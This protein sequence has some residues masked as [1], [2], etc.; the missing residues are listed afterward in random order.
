MMGVKTKPTIF[1]YYFL[2]CIVIIALLYMAFN[3]L[4]YPWLWYDEAGQF[5]I[6]KGLNHYSEPFSAP[7]SIRQVIVNNR[8]YNLDPGGFSILLHYWLLISDNYIFIRTLPFLFFL[9]FAFFLYKL[10]LNIIGS[11]LYAFICY[12]LVFVFGFTASRMIEVRAYS[13][14]MFGIM[15]VLFL[16]D[17][18]EKKKYKSLSLPFLISLIIA[19]FNT[20][21][22]EY[23]IFAFCVSLYV[24]FHIGK[25][26][27][28][29]IF[30]SLCYG[31]LPL[32]SVLLIVLITL[33]YQN[34]S[35][36]K[37]GYSHY[38]SEDYYLLYRRLF[39]VYI[40]NSSFVIYSYYK[41]KAISSL[42]YTS[43]MVSTTIV[44]LSFMGKYPWDYIR[45]VSV[46]L[47]LM[48]NLSIELY[49]RFSYKPFSA[50]IVMLVCFFSTPPNLYGARHSEYLNFI[51][52]INLLEK[53]NGKYRKIFVD[54]WY[55]PSIRYIYEYGI[56][57]EKRNKDDYP[58]TFVF[59][60]KIPKQLATDGILYS[61]PPL[62]GCNLFLIGRPRN[63]S[64]VEK[65]AIPHS[66]YNFL[67]F[68][69]NTDK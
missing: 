62:N 41:N 51:E 13:M 5:W 23:I 32:C 30:W 10:V 43:L 45:A 24:V 44:I 22:Y 2:G 14:E 19:I 67:F 16:I 52:A 15:L 56:Y 61:A 58:S 34:P 69:N 57:S 59:Q 55:N 50:V 49:N 37:T 9:G 11:R 6:S 53:D 4:T 64:I 27:S 8:Y 12:V 25:H 1:L 29:P 31:I 3:K 26:F 42:Q 20:S 36:S 38:L 66:D 39:L 46:P 60:Y 65:I 48:V 63:E 54:D 33:Q 35:I 18:W 28:R 7:S 68:R 21:R 17:K 40:L 47:L